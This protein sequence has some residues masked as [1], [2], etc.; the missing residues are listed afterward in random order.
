M[1]ERILEKKGKSVCKFTILIACYNKEKFI[2]EC[3]E[4]VKNQTYNNWECVIVDDCSTDSSYKYLKTI[5]DSRFT[6][7]RNS[8]RKFCSSTYAEALKHATGDVC[9]ILDGDDVLSHK[10]MS[11]V[12]KRYKA[13]PHIDFI[14]TQH[15][16]CGKSMQK[17]RVGLSSLPKHGK[18]LAEMANA[19]RH[20]FSHWR[21]FRLS[22]ADKG[23]LFPEGLEVSVDKNM[24]FILEELGRGG[25][26]PKKV[27]FYRYYKGNM[28][29][30]QGGRQKRT[31]KDM[32]ERR[33]NYRRKE[34]VKVYPVIEIG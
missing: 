12:A 3:V 13:H 26:L 31:T 5:T 18:S 32:A 22:L 11:V 30:V 25:F 29:L 28:S 15:F 6:V 1:T 33:I 17:I 4:S 9:G 19:G 7:I 8:S 23:V 27:Y 14:Y 20:C 24:G 21:T 16:W 34:G 2:K 10:A